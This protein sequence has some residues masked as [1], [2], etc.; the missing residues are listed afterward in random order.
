MNQTPGQVARW[1]RR[2]IALSWI[3]LIG[4]AVLSVLGWSHAAHEVQRTAD[5]LFE[6][7]SR[8]KAERL[9]ASVNHHLDLLRS[10]QSAFVASDQVDRAAFRRLHELAYA[11]EGYPALI[12]VQFA[13]LVPHADKARF[14]AGMRADGPHPGYSIH[15]P[16]ER[17]SYLP[18][19][20]VEPPDGN[21]RLLGYDQAFEAIRRAVME[22][23]RDTARAQ[24]SGPVQLVSGGAQAQGFVVRLPVYRAHQ[25][26]DTVAQ[27]RQAYLG[28]VGGAFQ[29]D[30]LVAAVIPTSTWDQWHLNIQDLGPATGGASTAPAPLFDSARQSSTAFQPTATPH[31]DD[32]RRR[33]TEVAGRRWALTLTRPPVGAWQQPYPLSVLAAGLL[34]TLGL[35]WAVR[36]IGTQQRQAAEMAEHLSRQARTNER[37]LSKVMDSTID[38]ILTLDPRG[39]VLSSNHAAQMIFIGPDAPEIALSPC[40]IDRLIPAPPGCPPQADMARYLQAQGLGVMDVSRRLQ[41]LRQDGHRFPLEL[42]VSPMVL[43]GQTQYVMVLRD[44]TEQHAA[45]QAALAAQRQLDE[46]DEMRRV[47]VHHAPYA[48][49]V[50]NRQGVVQAI[51]PAGEAL[52]GCTAQELVGR[53]STERFFDPEQVTERAHLLGLRLN[54]EIKDVQVFSHLARDAAGVP[55]EWALLR[56][57]GRRIMAELSVTELR[58]EQGRMNGYLAM[59]Q[60]ISARTEAEQQLQHQAQHDA[61]TG[62]PNRNMLQE[63]LKSAVLHAER[64]QQPLALMFLDLDRFK[65][66]ND[67]LGHH[68]GDNVILEVGRRLRTAMRTSDIVA[69]LGGDEFVV[70]LPQISQMD[71]GVVVAHKVLELFNEPLRVGPHELRLTPSIGLVVYPT[72]GTDAATLM[73]HADLAMYQAK[74]HGRNRVQVYSDQLESPTADKLVL[75]NDLYKALER[76]ELRLH[77]QPQFDCASGQIIGAEALLRWEHDGKLVPP[78]DFIPFAEETGLIVPM[79]EWVLRESCRKAQAWHLRTGWPLRIAVNLSAV[80]LE[81]TDIA[82]TV[83]R[84]LTETGL[85]PTMLELEITE[86]VVVRES[87]RAADILTQ[88]RSLGVS[89]AIDDFGVGYSSFGYLREL[90]VDRFKLDRSFLMAVPQSEGDCRLAAALIAMAH[91]LNVGIVAE[92]VENEE[93]L[94][95]LK[96][97]GCDEAQGYHLGRPMKED[98]F[99]A[100]LVEHSRLHAG[101]LKPITRM[102]N[103]APV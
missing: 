13:R 69:R 56:P 11:K 61:L 50:L 7:T 52:L 1:S 99:E 17:A 37:R 22:Q 14:E 34:G 91:R 32:R 2:W 73:R 103:H 57:D 81:H 70:L 18:V 53:A 68:V 47:I 67:T 26:I 62:L 15:P 51:N 66:I 95:F 10:F 6:N 59:A 60:D 25:P 44:L 42:S 93:Q 89:I 76:D 63:Q 28:Q 77:F 58:D 30:R 46:V 40:H 54:R 9:A 12:A 55:K 21:T 8:D 71:D 86:T 78:M 100:M 92:G 39:T 85:P 75:E 65:K 27:R 20:F 88:L 101:A 49:L 29:A 48:I 94:A 83:A 3:S 102:V 36:G 31:A 19:V 41:G 82:N 23:A 74:N 16:G 64:H 79:G 33:L 4:G 96:D 84:V 38:A 45:E 87:L 43:D 24:G 72:H 97:H 90:P 80:Q 5:V 98:A 35:W